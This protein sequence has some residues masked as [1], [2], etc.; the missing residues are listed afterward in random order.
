MNTVGEVKIYAIDDMQIKVITTVSHDSYIVELY[1]EGS[2]I[3]SGLIVA[4]VLEV[5][6][7]SFL[8]G[9]EIPPAI[10]AKEMN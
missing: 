1:L 8:K 3:M 4:K 9:I 6:G 5:V 2:K 10:Y 7:S